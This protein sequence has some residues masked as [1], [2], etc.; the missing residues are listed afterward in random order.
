MKLDCFY[1]VHPEST[2]ELPKQIFG[3][4][5][6]PTTYKVPIYDQLFTPLGISI[7][8]AYLNRQQAID[9]K[10]V[11][12]D[13]LLYNSDLI[14]DFTC[15]DKE[16]QEKVKQKQFIDHQVQLVRLYQQSK[17]QLKKY[18]EATHL[19]ERIINATNVLEQWD[20]KNTFPRLIVGKEE[21]NTSKWVKNQLLATLEYAR[22]IAQQIIDLQF[23]VDVVNEMLV[24][25]YNFS[26]RT[27]KY[28]LRINPLFL[29]YGR[30]IYEVPVDFTNFGLGAQFLN[31][32]IQRNGILPF[33]ISAFLIENNVAIIV[34]N[35]RYQNYDEIMF[36]DFT[37][38]IVI[39]KQAYNN[40]TK[41]NIEA[42][43]FE[44]TKSLPA[45]GVSIL[46]MKQI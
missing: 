19:V 9:Y 11:Q 45:H 23:Q 13:T 39:A 17:F 5:L 32:F 20:T 18:A 43:F 25:L 14:M 35:A 21:V 42:F 37:H 26:D 31:T 10:D 46:S 44:T 7:L 3:L 12:L 29:A 28:H 6:V 40:D 36:F 1:D 15:H 33:Q 22:V 24:G 4:N 16:Y 30:S 27:N 2:K 41:P 34:K 8:M 38:P